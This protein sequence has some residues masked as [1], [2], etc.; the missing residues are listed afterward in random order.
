M[1]N[2]RVYTVNNMHIEL[3]IFFGRGRLKLVL[4]LTMSVIILTFY[5]WVEKLVSIGDVVILSICMNARAVVIYAEVR[6][7]WQIGLGKLIVSVATNLRSRILELR[8]M[9][10]DVVEFVIDVDVAERR[11]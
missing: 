10:V 11:F 2:L 5:V 4:M 9:V 6:E 7:L 8:R 1:A 3:P